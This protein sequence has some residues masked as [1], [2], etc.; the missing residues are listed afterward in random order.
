MP[1]RLL[2]MMLAVCMI[3]ANR[4][5]AESTDCTTPVLIIPDGRITQGSFPQNT[6]YWYAVFG[7]AG[8]SYSVE[9]EPPA[10]NFFNNY[11]PQFGPISAYSPTDSL[12]ACR[13]TSTVSLTQN[14]GYSPVISKSGNGA[15]RRVSFLAGIT[16]LYLISATNIMGSGSYTFAAV[17][18]TLVNIRWN[19]LVGS[20]I[21]WV[22]T[23]VSE[24]MLSGSLRVLDMNGQV[25]IMV[26]INIPPGGR[27]A[28][29]S[30]ISDLNVPRNS[31]GSAL[32]SHNG[33]PNAA[34]GEA[35]MMGGAVST[36]EKFEPIVPR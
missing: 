15:G 23:N 30:A 22:I 34:I 27:I 10:D 19:T 26:Q 6:T 14:S 9:F 21:L 36:P 35:F 5:P 8:H 13:G 16:G 25:L 31:A 17:D 2:F 28:R 11:R 12:Q 20:D 29:S 3:F 4:V 1:L 32:F 33:P 18:T 24:M 7:Q